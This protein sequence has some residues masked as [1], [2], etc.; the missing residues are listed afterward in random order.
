MDISPIV[1]VSSIGVRSIF[2]GELERSKPLGGISIA[3][4]FIGNLLSS[5]IWVLRWND[6]CESAVCNPVSPA[7]NKVPG[8]Y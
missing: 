6:P 7:A 3:A 4:C 8:E 1:R 2:G 5:S